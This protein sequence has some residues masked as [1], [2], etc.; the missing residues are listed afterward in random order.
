MLPRIAVPMT[1]NKVG[2]TPMALPTWISS[3]SSMIGNSKNK[4]RKT[5]IKDSLT[6]ERLPIRVKYG[7]L[8]LI[9][10]NAAPSVGQVSARA[11]RTKA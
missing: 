10:A 5:R 3:A 11:S 8:R 9:Q 1:S 7:V 2:S 6:E 4:N